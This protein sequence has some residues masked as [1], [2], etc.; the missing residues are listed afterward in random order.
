MWPNVIRAALLAGVASAAVLTSSIV[1]AKF[2]HD[3]ALGNPW[4]WG[5]LYAPPAAWRW[6]QAWGHAD[7]YRAT[8]LQG[9]SLAAIVAVAPAA[10]VRMA[11]MYGPLRLDE[12][13]AE[14]GLGRPVD[15]RRSGHISKRV[16][17]IVLGRAGRFG[18]VLRDQGD[19]HFLGLG[20]SRSGKGTTW[21]VPT[22]LTHPGSMVIFDPKGELAA[23]TGRQRRRYGDVHI[24]NPT[25]RQSARFNPLLELRDGEHLRGDA[26]MA[27]HML[28]YDGTGDGKDKFFDPAAAQLLTYIITHVCTHGDHTLGHVAA[29]AREIQ[30]GKYPKHGEPDVLAHFAAH[31]KTN[32]RTRDS[33][34]ATVTTRLAM[35]DDPI[36]R[37]ATSESDFRAGDLMAEDDP[38]AVYLSIPAAHSSRLRPVT[39]LVLQAIW[40]AM[41]HDE[42]VTSDG[43]IKQR[44]CL[45]LIDEFPQLGQMDVIEKGIA[46]CAGYGLRVAL[47]CQDEDQIRKIYGASQSITANCST[48]AVIPGFS[49]Q[50]LRT[51]Q[52]WA[53][54]HTVFHASRQYGFK[55]TTNQSESETRRSVLNA[56]SLLLRG[57]E[58]VLIFTHGVPP[59]WLRKIRYYR[60][61]PFKRMSDR[62]TVSQPAMTKR[63]ALPP[64]LQ[65][66]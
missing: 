33:I 13:N 38:V 35:M 57:K 39:R 50:S 53:G 45:A 64:W 26:Q 14:S 5:W 15:L 40:S 16:S 34:N 44:G 32:D 29:V 63:E 49:G 4:L 25:S 41:T 2:G 47:I 19:G 62:K 52:G 18:K 3:P 51:I 54:E 7:P 37:H 59:T 46:V 55:G 24:F 22:A 42:H 6:W 56:R 58:E 23:I 1:A 65:T 21:I 27:A 36:V 60:E 17:G 48:I 9:L 31:H 66:I 20:P 8:F 61:Q 11:Q 28:A 43:R 10:L 30:A 12:S